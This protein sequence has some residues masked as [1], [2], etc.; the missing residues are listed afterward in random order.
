MTGGPA[1]KDSKAAP[2]PGKAPSGVVVDPPIAIPGDDKKPPSPEK[3]DRFALRQLIHRR[4]RLSRHRDSSSHHGVAFGDRTG[5]I[6]E[7][8][9]AAHALVGIGADHLKLV[10]AHLSK[11]GGVVIGRLA[12]V[13]EEPGAHH[14]LGLGEAGDVDIEPAEEPQIALRPEMEQLAA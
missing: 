8:V 9:A 1:P 12:R 4:K 6:D 14:R 13:V 5:T 2:A 10:I 3:P 11:E 7:L